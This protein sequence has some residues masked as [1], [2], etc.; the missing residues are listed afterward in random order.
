MPNALM[1]AMAIG[2]PCISTDC[3]P[4]GAREIINNNYDGFITEIGNH[5]ELA[6]Q[7]DWCLA[8]KDEVEQM[9]KKAMINMER[10]K[11]Q[12]IFD[13]WEGFLDKLK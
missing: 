6:K 1:E 5:K 2:V 9:S 10:F 8:H 3:K 4:G 11:S 13:K 7:I 12:N